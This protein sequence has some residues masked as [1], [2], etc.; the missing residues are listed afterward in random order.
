MEY[1][2]SVTRRIRTL[3]EE[4]GV[5]LFERTRQGMRAGPGAAVPPPA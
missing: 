2:P 1:A 4:L 3:E 5:A